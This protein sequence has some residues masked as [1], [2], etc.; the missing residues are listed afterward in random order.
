LRRWAVHPAR[1]SKITP[2]APRHGENRFLLVVENI[3]AFDTA[4]R[5]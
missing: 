1:K 5:T 2:G 4:S 3:A